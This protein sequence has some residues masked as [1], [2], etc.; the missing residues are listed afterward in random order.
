V[1]VNDHERGKQNRHRRRHV[2]DEPR[3]GHGG[4][5]DFPITS[6]PA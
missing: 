4:P 2:E 3:H 5:R 1:R 6:T